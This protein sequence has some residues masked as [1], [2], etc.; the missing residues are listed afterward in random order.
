[1][2]GQYGAGDVEDGVI[3]WRTDEFHVRAVDKL[4]TYDALGIVIE[5]PEREAVA[6]RDPRGEGAAE[7]GDSTVIKAVIDTDHTDQPDV[8][9]NGNAVDAVIKAQGGG[10]KSS[11]PGSA[12]RRRRR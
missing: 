1:M 12:S 2:Q 7:E 8:K 5:D 6:G 4:K 11:S 3:T 10:A 9:A